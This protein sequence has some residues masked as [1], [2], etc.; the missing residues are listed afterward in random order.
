M[1]F[2]DYEI[3]GTIGRD[4]EGLWLGWRQL[5]ISARGHYAIHYV[6]VL[7]ARDRAFQVR[8]LREA[9][10]G[11]TADHP[12]LVRVHEVICEAD[13]TAVVTD[14]VDGHSLEEVLDRRSA[15]EE[16]FPAEVTLE[17]TAHLLEAAHH[18]HGI[19][20]GDG[21]PCYHGRISARKILLTV[22]GGMKLCGFGIAS[23]RA[24]RRSSERLGPLADQFAIGLVFLDLLIGRRVSLDESLQPSM[25]RWSRTLD[26]AVRSL[27]MSHPALPVLLRLLAPLPQD[28][29]ASCGL[30]ATEL[31][32]LRTA[33]PE[34]TA[35]A[36]FAADEVCAV[37]A[38]DC[39]E[40]E[41]EPREDDTEIPNEWLEDLPG[42]QEE[43]LVLTVGEGPLFTSKTV[44]FAHDFM[45]RAA[46]VAEE[47]PVVTSLP[48]RRMP[49]GSHLDAAMDTAGY[50]SNPFLEASK[51]P[52]FTP[53]IAPPAPMMSVPAPPP[54]VRAAAPM[55]G[56]GAASSTDTEGTLPFAATYAGQSATFTRSV[57]AWVLSSET[58]PIPVQHDPEATQKLESNPAVPRRR[59]SLDIPVS[60][61]GQAV[62]RHRKR[63][64][65]GQSSA[66][67][68]KGAG[69]GWT[70][71]TRTG[72]NGHRRPGSELSAS[73]LVRTWQLQGVF[74]ASNVLKGL[75][76]GMAILVLV[77][78]VEVF[79]RQWVDAPAA[80]RAGQESSGVHPELVPPGDPLLGD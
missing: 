58:A 16:L 40:T 65:S 33:Y 63:K 53:T 44:P 28:R 59:P 37:R 52:I 72:R 60:I 3:V 41:L 74:D 22:D 79:K 32:R 1:A 5:P 24:E 13:R 19:E 20:S 10:L 55:G 68:R 43:D 29:Y 18:I 9:A 4:S 2:D 15:G 30:A 6:D 56:L 71:K 77:L 67:R 36:G 11:G 8:L 46:C 80:E 70:L 12:A 48:P 64:R 42:G 62:K 47:S 31:R 49:R 27:P 78:T 76:M 45:P 73:G 23:E 38:D 50:G 66:R 25:G 34:G 61:P 7:L 51:T 14:Y 17:L 57:P 26:E 54:P 75:A 39:N 69:S 35:L 21:E